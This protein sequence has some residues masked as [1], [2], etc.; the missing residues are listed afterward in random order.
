MNRD[1]LQGICQQVS[2]RLK[3][4]WGTLNGDLRAVADG[5]RDRLAGRI[6]EQ[7][8]ISKQEADQQLQDFMRRNRNWWNLTGR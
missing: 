2:G 3:Q 7:R 8:G 4:Q 1:R 5:T 6:Q